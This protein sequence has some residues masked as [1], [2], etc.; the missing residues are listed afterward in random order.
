[1]LDKLKAALAAAQEEGRGDIAA[2]IQA[3]I[4]KLEAPASSAQ[5]G[6]TGN[7]PPG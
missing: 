1:M 4:D 2:E 3:L 6:G 5:G 7:G